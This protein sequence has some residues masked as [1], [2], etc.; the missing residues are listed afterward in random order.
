MVGAA[1]VPTRRQ[2]R[3]SVVH[4]RHRRARAPNTA[5]PGRHTCPDTAA[6]ATSRCARGRAATVALQ[7]RPA[8]R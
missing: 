1:T 4:R 3:R 6:S 2:A 8:L 7:S 5:P